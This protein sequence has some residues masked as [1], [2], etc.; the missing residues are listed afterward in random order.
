MR[1]NNY[2][3]ELETGE[4]LWVREIDLEV[5]LTVVIRLDEL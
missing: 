1:E 2:V 3:G 5:M 4:E